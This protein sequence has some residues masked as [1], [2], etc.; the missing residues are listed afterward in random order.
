MFKVLKI[1][2][3]VLIGLNPSCHVLKFG[4]N[5]PRSNWDM[6]QH[7]NLQ[8]HDLES[9][10]H[11]WRSTIKHFAKLSAPY[12]WPYMWSFTETLLAV[13]LENLHT[14][15]WKVARRKKERNP[16]LKFSKHVERQVNKANRILGL[17]D[18]MSS[19][20]MEVM[21]K[22]FTSLLRPHLEFG[23]VAYQTV[24]ITKQGLSRRKWKC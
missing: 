16:E 11:S 12:P 14:I 15:C 9:Q 3:T 21:K 20:D 23:D 19:F 24:E 10:G 8:S 5:C 6:T 4:D 22:L 7:V 13:S 1:F 17:V 2:F 18:P